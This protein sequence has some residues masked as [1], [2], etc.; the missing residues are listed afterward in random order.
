MSPNVARH[1]LRFLM[2]VG[3]RLQLTQALFSVGSPSVLRI[4]GPEADILF[5]PTREKTTMKQSR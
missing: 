5:R 4:L 2:L 3:K 1:S